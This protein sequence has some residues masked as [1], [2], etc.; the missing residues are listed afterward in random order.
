MVRTYVSTAQHKT[1]IS[2]EDPAEHPRSQHIP[3]PPPSLHP[4]LSPFFL[5]SVAFTQWHLHLVHPGLRQASQDHQLR[6]VSA[7]ISPKV[8]V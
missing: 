7:E 2:F 1:P 8:R 3:L 6:Q 5:P 4:F